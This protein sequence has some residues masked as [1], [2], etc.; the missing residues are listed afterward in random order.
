MSGRVVLGVALFAACAGCTPIRSTIAPPYVID[1]QSLGAEELESHA[2]Q[3]CAAQSHGAPPPPRKFTTDGCSA[4]RDARWRGC[5][6]EHDIAY[7]CGAQ[8]RRVADEDFR[9]CVRGES[10]ALNASL[11]YAGVRLGGGRFAPFPWRFGYGYPWP[12]RRSSAQSEARPQTAL[13]SP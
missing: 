11:M 9:A 5:C 4:Y 8:P 6:I 10:S 3:R 7:W 1:G 12:H 13:T 2:N